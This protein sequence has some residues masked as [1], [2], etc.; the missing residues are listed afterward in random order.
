[1]VVPL[2][3]VEMPGSLRV[4]GHRYGTLVARRAK[5]KAPDALGYG[6]RSALVVTPG[7]IAEYSREGSGMSE[8]KSISVGLHNGVGLFALAVALICAVRFALFYLR[9]RYVPDLPLSDDTLEYLEPAVSFLEHGR[10]VNADGSPWLWRP[11]G[12]P[13]VIAALFELFGANN[14]VSVIALQNIGFF[15]CACVVA[16][17]AHRLAG[18]FAAIVATILYLTDFSTFYYTNT[19]PCSV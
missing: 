9:Y 18:S 8:R 15:V 2:A 19:N 1:M 10:F 14:L 6:R 5:Q 13:L 7:P 17:L 3:A 11:P 12:Y 16:T 4:P